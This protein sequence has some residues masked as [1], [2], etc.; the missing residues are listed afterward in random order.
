LSTKLK[1][2]YCGLYCFWPVYGLVSGFWTGG[3]GLIIGL[4]DGWGQGFWTPPTKHGFGAILET[5]ELEIAEACDFEV[6]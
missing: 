4:L 2:G 5:D 3:T 1:I 6:F